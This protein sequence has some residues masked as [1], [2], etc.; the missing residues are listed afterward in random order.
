MKTMALDGILL[1]KI[2]PEISKSLPARIQKIYA[3]S[4]TEILFQIHGKNGKQQ[5]LISCHTVYNRMLLTTRSYPTPEEPSNFIMLLRKYLEGSTLESLKQQGLDRWCLMEIKHRNALGDLE[6]LHA[7]IE[8]MGKYANFILLDKN[9]KILDALKRIPPFENNNRIIQPG[10]VFTPVPPQN[11]K[12]PF[13]KG[14]FIDPEISLTKQF[15]GF[16]P[17]LSKEIEY[18]MEQGQSFSSIMEEIENSTD[19]FIA[20]QKNEAV[21]HCIEL[22]HLG[23]CISYPFFEGLDVLYYHKEEKDRI[24]QLSGDMEH[25]IKRQ[26]KHQK[27]KLPRLYEALDEAKNC[28]QYRLY[29]DLLYTYGIQDTKGIKEIELEDYNTGKMIKIPLDEKFDGPSNAKKSY[30]KYQKLKKGQS[31]LQEQITI[32]ENEI[33]YFEGLQEQ[34]ELADFKTAEEIRIELEKQG[35][36]ST[37]NKKNRK[38]KENPISFTTIKTSKGILIS[39]GKNNLQNEQLTWHYAKK[40]ETWL[41]TKDYHGSHV[42]IHNANPDEETLRFGAM[43]AAY[44]S[45]GRNSSSV[46]VNYCPVKNLKKIPGSKPG[47]VSLGSYKTIYIDPDV[48]YLESSGVETS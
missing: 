36:L 27:T 40:N 6:T 10:V 4:N 32:C 19:L 44:Y 26:L 23:K 33:S 39:Y 16:S 35:Y 34:L 37:K 13:E 46:P 38:K 17:F 43:I 22:K 3:I 15:D 42:V 11:K 30:Q 1:H 8:L 12:N 5:L 28:D 18:R 2:V 21:F 25:F 41:H 14:I 31:H 47:M 7:S 9:N 45:K 48:D 29:G 20:N 24:R